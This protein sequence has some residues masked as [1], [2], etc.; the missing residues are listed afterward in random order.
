MNP[1]FIVVLIQATIVFSAWSKLSK[2]IWQAHSFSKFGRIVELSRYSPAIA[3]GYSTARFR[4]NGFLPWISSPEILT[5]YR[6][7]V[8]VFQISSDFRKIAV[9]SPSP[10]FPTLLGLAS[11]FRTDNR[12]SPPNTAIND[13]DQGPPAVFDAIDFDQINRPTPIRFC[14]PETA[15]WLSPIRSLPFL[16]HLQPV[17]LHQALNQLGVEVN[18]ALML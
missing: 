7:S 11:P 6:G 9:S 12:Q 17:L 8:P 13:R 5:R 14:K 18:L 15:D 1:L 16:L 10:V 2:F 4:K 3:A